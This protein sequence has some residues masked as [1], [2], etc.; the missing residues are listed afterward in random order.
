MPNQMGLVLTRAEFHRFGSWG[1]GGGG[2]G[3]GGRCIKQTSLL[4]YCENIK[5]RKMFNLIIA[6]F[7][8]EQCWDRSCIKVCLVL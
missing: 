7:L 2:G 3:G 5:I 8:R 1:G 4:L 6:N